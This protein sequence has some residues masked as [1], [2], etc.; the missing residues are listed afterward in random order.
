MRCCHFCHRSFNKSNFIHVFEFFFTGICFRRTP[1]PRSAHG[2]AVYDKKLWIYAGY[3]GNARLNDMWTISLTVSAKVSSDGHLYFSAYSWSFCSCCRI[4]LYFSSSLNSP[5]LIVNIMI[6]SQRRRTFINGKKLNKK[7]SGHRLA[8]I[9]Q[10]PWLTIVCTYF[11]AKVDCKSP[12]H[13]LNSI[14]KPNCKFLFIWNSI[15]DR[16]FD[17]KCIFLTNPF[18]WANIHL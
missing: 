16:K 17:S 12:T 6:I 4:S 10:L 7:A 8:V 13:C 3:D 14:F 11:R 2:A 18:S 5:C 9:S 15:L 1:V